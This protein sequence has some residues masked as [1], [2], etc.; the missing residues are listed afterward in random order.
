MTNYIKCYVNKGNNSIDN[1]RKEKIIIFGNK[2]RLNKMMVS[3][4]L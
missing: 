4:L 3:R 2:D 1:E